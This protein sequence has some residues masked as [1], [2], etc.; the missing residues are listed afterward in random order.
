MFSNNPGFYSRCQWHVF[1]YC[2][3]VSYVVHVCL[4][5]LCEIAP[6]LRPTGLEQSGKVLVAAFTPAKV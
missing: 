4:E 6:L 5:G 2:D 1:F 3:D